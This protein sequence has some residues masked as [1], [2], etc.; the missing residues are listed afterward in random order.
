M[1]ILLFFIGLLSDNALDQ[2][3][4]Q[5]HCET[6]Y[7]YLDQN[8]LEHSRNEFLT[9]LEK[10]PENLE[11]LLGIAE[12]Y[13]RMESHSTSE[14]YLQRFIELAPEDI[15]GYLKL[16]CVMY[17][18][19]R[20]RDALDYT[21]SALDLDPSSSELWLLHAVS[22][23]GAGDTTEAESSLNRL[24]FSG[25]E[26]EPEA[27]TILSSIYR[28]RNMNHEA[29]EILLPAAAIDYAP[30]FAGLALVYL[31]WNDYM[32]TE[33]AISAYLQLSPNGDWADSAWLIL[34]ELA[35]SGEYMP[36][37]IQPGND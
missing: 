34:E 20:Y 1:L 16:A 14:T 11:S 4:I 3:F 23:L 25:T 13:F 7:A 12:V 26:Q 22:A 21:F 6:G 24:L 29:Q 10:D 9:A 18:A 36:S 27:R 30:A 37:L 8:L 35:A 31:K 33:E 19:Q 5:L 15:R 2:Y 17:D 28:I 32:R